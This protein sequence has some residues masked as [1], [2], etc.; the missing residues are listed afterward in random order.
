MSILRGEDVV[1]G[2]GMENAAA[3]GTPVTPQMWIPGRTPTGVAPVLEKTPLRETRGT[4]V[5]SYASEIT[6]KRV[7][8]DLEFNVRSES[9]GYLLRSLLGKSTST[10]GSGGTFN[11]AFEILPN[12]PQHPTLTLGL[13]QPGNQDYIYA[14]ALVR[15]LKLDISPDDLVRATV[16]FIGASEAEKSPAYTVAFSD[17]DYHFRHQDVSIKL[18]ATVDELPSASA[19]KLKNFS[20]EIPNGGRVDQNIS[21]LN[22]GDVLATSFDITGSFELDLKDTNLHDV[23]DGGEYQALEITIERADV[24][25]GSGVNPSLVITLPKISISGWTPNRPIDDVVREQ[26]SFMA[27]YDGDE[28]YAVEID[29]VSATDDYLHA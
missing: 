18:A 24:E 4:K 12:N 1:I 22:P 8:G 13:S 14:K 15:S 23:Y 6:Q 11:H 5:N 27:H 3:R 19:V 28:D 7:E 20:L 17:A 16:S 26:I 29:L 21:E 9:I 25:I 10:S 2:V